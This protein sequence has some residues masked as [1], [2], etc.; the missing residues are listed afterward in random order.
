MTGRGSSNIGPM[1]CALLLA[2]YF[3]CIHAEPQHPERW[4]DA[5]RTFAAADANSP[6]PSNPIVFIGSSSIK[7]WETLQRDM[8]PLNVINRGF[9]GS[10]MS[11]AVY[12]LDALVLKYKPRAVVVYEGDNDIG[13]YN[14]PPE[15]VLRGF[16]HLVSRMRAEARDARI[17][18]LAIKP[19]RSRW[20]WWHQMKRTNDLIREFC[21]RQ[22]GV[23]FVDIAS[24]MLDVTGKPRSDIFSA[25]QLHL[26]AAGYELWKAI[27]KPVLLAH[28]APR[29]TGIL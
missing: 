4:A 7:F 24:P 6:P 14:V 17:Y 2:T 10:T 27:L 13:L 8:A 26:N 1:F 28:E 21:A 18:F 15:E 12:W 16:T 23:Y 22:S 29:L 3:G 19:S 5:I 25:D 11:D 20:Q 9:G